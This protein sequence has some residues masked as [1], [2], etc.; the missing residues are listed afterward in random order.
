MRLLLAAALLAGCGQR[1][2]VSG[3]VVDKGGWVGD[4]WIV[5]QDCALT[6]ALSARIP[7]SEGDYD[8][9]RIGW[10]WPQE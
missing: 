7:V 10:W 5:V 6:C 9:I 1:L 3:Q 2:V 8:A 4:R